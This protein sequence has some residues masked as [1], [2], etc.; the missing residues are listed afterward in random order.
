[1]IY[2]WKISGLRMNGSI[3]GSD[4]VVVLS[5]FLIMNYEGEL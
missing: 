5:D 4:G 3:K 2:E 1:M